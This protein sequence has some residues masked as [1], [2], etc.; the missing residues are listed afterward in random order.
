MNKYKYINASGFILGTPGR[1]RAFH[2]WDKSNKTLCPLCGKK[3]LWLVGKD[4]KVYE[5]GPPYFEIC[6]SCG[7]EIPFLKFGE[8][9]SGMAQSAKKEI[10]EGYEKAKSEGCEVIYIDI[11][12]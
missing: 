11:E 4:K 3:G 6:L 10:I 12:N 7:Y 8:P 1:G 9:G 5:S 2:P